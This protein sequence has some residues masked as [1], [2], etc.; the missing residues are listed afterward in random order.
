MSQIRSI[1]LQNWDQYPPIVWKNHH[2]GA[3]LR[4]EIDDIFNHMSRGYD[5]SSFR[6][7]SHKLGKINP[8]I[9]ISESEKEFLITAELPA[10]NEN[11]IEITL[12][13]AQ[14]TIKGEKKIDQN[15]EKA[16]H[17]IAERTF[18]N[19]ERSFQLPTEIDSHKTSA[20]FKQGVLCITL[21]KTVDPKQ[22]AKK[23]SING[24]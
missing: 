22:F 15:T 6:P 12:T 13:E 24:A 1:Y 16:D 3:R 4:Y 10:M 18:G 14:L 9:D 23:I 7:A 8:N 17:H 21:P 20:S 11:D 19:F 2:I 5:I